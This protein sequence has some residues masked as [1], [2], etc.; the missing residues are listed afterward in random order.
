M[1]V[2]GSSPTT[3]SQKQTKWKRELVWRGTAG[4]VLWAESQETFFFALVTGRRCS[5]YQDQQ[6]THTNAGCHMPEPVPFTNTPEA[7]IARE[8]RDPTV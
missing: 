3:A 1:V 2:D 7:L 6:V 5:S 4:R 8:R